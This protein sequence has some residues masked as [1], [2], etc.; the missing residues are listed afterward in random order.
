MSMKL[1][2]SG[3]T[4][5]KTAI[6]SWTLKAI[7]TGTGEEVYLNTKLPSGQSW[8]N[9]DQALAEIGKLVGDEFSKNF[10]LSYFS[11]R[12]QKT[13][14]VFTGL[15]AGG[16]DAVLRELRSMRLVLDAQPAGTEKFQIQLPPG[17]VTDIVQDAV[18]RPLNAKMGEACFTLGG[19]TAAEVSV[20][21]T[22]NCANPQMKA[23]LDSGAPAGWKFTPAKT[24]V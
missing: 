12:P 15:P 22:G 7:D 18:L 23:K 4:I 20:T 6:T 2:A 10:F 8:A 24:T 21:L 3:L 11:Y 19:A 17:N 13:T 1:Q 5:S 9:E 14:L 16:S